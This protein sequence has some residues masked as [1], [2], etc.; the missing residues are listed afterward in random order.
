MAGRCKIIHS[1]YAESAVE[2]AHVGQVSVQAV[3]IQAIADNKLVWDLEAAVL[4]A[5]VHPTALG[6]LQQGAHLQHLEG[7]R[8][9]IGL[10]HQ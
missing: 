10:S 3:R 5:D 2:V 9:L 6:L 7:F 4:E 8:G 1:L